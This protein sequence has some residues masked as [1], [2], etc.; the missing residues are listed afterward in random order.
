[1]HVLFVRVAG[2]P[3]CVCLCVCARARLI[4]SRRLFYSLL[5][6]RGTH[7]RVHSPR[8]KE[9]FRHRIALALKNNN[10]NNNN[11]NDYSTESDSVIPP[12]QLAKSTDDPA[13]VGRGGGGRGERERE[14]EKKTHLLGDWLTSF[15]FGGEKQGRDPVYSASTRYSL[16]AAMRNR[17]NRKHC[18]HDAWHANALVNIIM[19]W[20]HKIALNK[21]THGRFMQLQLID[22]KLYSVKEVFS[23]N[24]VQLDAGDKKMFSPGETL[25]LQKEVPAMSCSVFPGDNNSR[26]SMF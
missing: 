21:L 22:H 3:F 25:S 10:N 15:L 4:F 8:L 18:L 26:R 1:M 16:C 19:P 23:A 7:L 9:L 24:I 5:V 11:K 20:T 13:S 6:S 2:V 17:S 12:T 14:G